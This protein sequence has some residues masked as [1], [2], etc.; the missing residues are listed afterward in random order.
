MHLLCYKAGYVVHLCW[1]VHLV[2]C[3]TQSLGQY[4]IWLYKSKQCHKQTLGYHG[5]MYCALHLVA[6]TRTEDSM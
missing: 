1:V 6:V 3:N 4:I 5:S 2:Y